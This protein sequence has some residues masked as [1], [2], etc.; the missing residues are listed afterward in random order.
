MEKLKGPQKKEE[1]EIAMAQLRRNY[2]KWR[3][4]KLIKKDGFFIIYN[5]FYISEKLKHIK[6]NALK[7]YVYLG[8]H[9]KNETGEC[10]HSVERI[11]DYFE[12][13]KRTVE[14]ALGNLEELELIQRIQKG[15]KRV[16]NTFLKPY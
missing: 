4:D 11:A 16:A 6:G 15:F 5:D 3:K 9:V 8:I 12:M 2:G 13:D 1:A 7:V 14:R 10:W